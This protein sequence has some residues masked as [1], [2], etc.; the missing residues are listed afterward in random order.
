MNSC[1]SL[2]LQGPERIQPE[3][4]LTDVHLGL[5]AVCCHKDWERSESVSWDDSVF[6]NTPSTEVPY[7]LKYDPLP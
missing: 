2:H 4:T 3:V 1:W 5:D 6:S 7:R